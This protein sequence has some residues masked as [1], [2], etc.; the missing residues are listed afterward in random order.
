MQGNRTPLRL[1]PGTKWF[2]S[3]LSVNSRLKL[4]ILCQFSDSMLGI[5]VFI[6]VIVLIRAIYFPFKWSCSWL[7]RTY[8]GGN[9]EMYR[10]ADDDS[11]Q[12]KLLVLVYAVH[13]L[14]ESK[15]F[16]RWYRKLKITGLCSCR[17]MT[18]VVQWLRSALSKGPNRV[19]VSLPS[20]EH[21]KRSSFRNVVFF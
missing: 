2:S 9:T 17:Y 3:L 14:V 20:P 15:G 10:G 5:F 8:I 12:T 11:N 13:F 4:Y 16:W 6:S 18:W 7:T 1:I 19:S 21:G